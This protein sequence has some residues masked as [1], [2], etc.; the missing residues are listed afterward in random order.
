[1]NSKDSAQSNI[2]HSKVETPVEATP[3]DRSRVTGSCVSDAAIIDLA[4]APDTDP[5]PHE[6]A[7]A[8]KLARL[9]PSE[10][11]VSLEE[12]RGRVAAG[13]FSPQALRALADAEQTRLI[14]NVRQ[15]KRRVSSGDL[16]PRT[17]RALASAQEEL[18]KCAP[19]SEGSRVIAPLPS[20]VPKE[21]KLTILVNMGFEE[22]NARAAL[23]SAQDD[24]DIAV[25]ML[26]SLDKAR[27]RVGG[28]TSLA[29][30]RVENV[31]GRASMA[32]KASDS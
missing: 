1:M 18:G 22:N 15:L 28:L 4:S 30:M 32:F 6:E 23:E 5:L 8:S 11:Q 9:N 14:E 16:S 26:L 25:T 27:E 19:Q 2:E 3:V 29:Q 20:S 13:D 24:L 12:L 10:K 17:L 7:S 21:E 31:E